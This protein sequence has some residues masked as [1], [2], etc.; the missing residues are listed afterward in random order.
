M[1]ETPLQV[2][3]A[4][5]IRS[6]YGAGVFI[7]K[8]HASAYVPPG[9]PDLVGCLRGYF[10]AIEVKQPGRDLDPVQRARAEQ[11]RRSGA[12]VCKATTPEE[13]LTFLRTLP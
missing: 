11:L 9:I 1:K 6:E 8:L 2:S 13:A 7:F 3:I 4:K 12:Y 5:A 10:F